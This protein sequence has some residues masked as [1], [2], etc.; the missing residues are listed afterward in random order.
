MG[1]NCKWC[2][3][4]SSKRNCGVHRQSPIDM[5]RYVGEDTHPEHKECLDWHWM[6]YKD[7]TCTFDRMKSEFESNRHALQIWIPVRDDGQIDCWE[8]G[9]GRRF[10]RLDYSK[11]FPDWWWLQRTDISVPSQHTQEGNRYAAEVT[12][13]HFYQ[14]AHHKNE[15]RYKLSTER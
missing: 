14:I 15:V 10:P 4:N 5:R 13:A 12:L 7:D 3:E 9:K 11:G 1:N 2:P 6:Q 8:K